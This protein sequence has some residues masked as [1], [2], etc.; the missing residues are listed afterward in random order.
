ML[1][2]EIKEYYNFNFL[3]YYMIIFG[4]YIMNVRFFSIVYVEVVCWFI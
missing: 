2:I 3:L 1:I 4:L